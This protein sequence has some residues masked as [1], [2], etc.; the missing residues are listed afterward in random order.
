MQRWQKNAEEKKAPPAPVKA[1]AMRRFVKLGAVY[2]TN[3]LVLDGLNPG[4]EVIVEGLQ[5]ATEA[6]DI[7]IIKTTAVEV[8]ADADYLLKNTQ[9]DMAQEEKLDKVVEEEL[10]ENN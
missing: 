7:A 3:W 1:K 6:S 10:R 2:G 4:D 5:N 9:I 8:P